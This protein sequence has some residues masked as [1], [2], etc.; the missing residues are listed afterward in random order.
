MRR[1][2]LDRDVFLYGSLASYFPIVGIGRDIW[3][4]AAHVDL[5]T[6]DNLRLC[7]LT[8]AD[9]DLVGYALGQ[10]LMNDR[11]L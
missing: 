2:C 8:A 7:Y 10:N 5:F 9:K 11:H 1:E 4:L 3:D 6:V